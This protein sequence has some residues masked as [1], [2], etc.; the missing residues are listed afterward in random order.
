[1]ITTAVY[2][3]MHSPSPNGS[4]SITRR[5]EHAM[6]GFLSWEDVDI[7]LVEAIKEKCFTSRRGAGCNTYIACRIN[8][9]KPDKESERKREREES[10]VDWISAA[11]C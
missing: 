6:V 2:H 3:S 5:N 1:M 9:P 4:S 10:A 11:L 7:D 8:S